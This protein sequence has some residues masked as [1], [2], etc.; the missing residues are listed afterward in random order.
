MQWTVP[1]LTAPGVKIFVVGIDSKRCAAYSDCETGAGCA[2]NS[3]GP[4]QAICPKRF[5]CG[6]KIVRV[7][8]CVISGGDEDRHKPYP[9]CYGR[10]KSPSIAPTES[11][12]IAFISPHELEM[13]SIIGS[14]GM[15][16]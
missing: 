1:N 16:G 15:D 3:N 5:Q 13:R 14:F 12:L 10:A 11:A 2:S 6:V 9:Q 8:D 7:L 4:Y